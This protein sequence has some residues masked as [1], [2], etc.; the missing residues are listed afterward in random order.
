MPNNKHSMCEIKE[1]EVESLIAGCSR[2]LC[3]RGAV[4]GGELIQ[5]GFLIT[6]IWLL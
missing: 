2:E 3:A 5:G 4:D 1:G 6:Q